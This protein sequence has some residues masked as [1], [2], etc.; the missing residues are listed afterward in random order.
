MKNISIVVVLLFASSVAFAQHPLYKK[1]PKAKNYKVAQE[2]SLPATVVSLYA[3]P[4]DK[5]EAGANAK[6]R[7]LKQDD[8]VLISGYA[9]TGIKRGTGANAKNR[10]VRVARENTEATITEEEN[11]QTED[12]GQMLQRK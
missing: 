7:T 10:Y 9:Q 4:S 5:Y 12:N 3:Q 6:N 11:M 2:E 8:S 1:G